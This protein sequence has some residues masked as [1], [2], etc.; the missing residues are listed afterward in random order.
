MRYTDIQKYQ[1]DNFKRLTG[2]QRSTFD[3]MVKAIKEHKVANR[4][5]PTR[6]AKPKTSTEDGLLMLLM[7][8]REY[9]TFFHIASAYGISEMQC[10]RIVTRYE[11]I[12][13]ESKDFRLPSKRALHDTENILEVVVVDASEHPVERPKKSSGGTIPGRRSATR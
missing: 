10:W 8:Y 12:L 13:L 6:G 2:V 7:Y 9:R 5:H 4:K 1:G 11:K 3:L